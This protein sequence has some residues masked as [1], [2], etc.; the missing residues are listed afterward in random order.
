M[1]L[2]LGT[3]GYGCPPP[4][5]ASRPHQLSPPSPTTWHLPLPGQFRKPQI[6]PRAHLQHKVPVCPLHRSSALDLLTSGGSSPLHPSAELSAYTLCG[7]VGSP[8]LSC[9]ITKR[10]VLCSAQ[11]KLVFQLARSGPSAANW[12]PPPLLGGHLPRATAQAWRRGRGCEPQGCGPASGPALPPG[13]APTLKMRES[14]S[15]RSFRAKCFQG[16]R[17]RVRA[18]SSHRSPS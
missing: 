17:K 2:E 15:P 12:S 13:W 10:W 1:R 8:E 18:A 11:R 9:S 6:C 14:A 7:S 3:L 5:G 16:T 4:T